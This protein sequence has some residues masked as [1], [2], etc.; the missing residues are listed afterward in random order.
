MMNKVDFKIAFYFSPHIRYTSVIFALFGFALLFEVPIAGVILCLLSLLF[1]TTHYRFAVDLDQKVYHDYLWIVG[2]KS[3]EK[4]KFSSIEYVF[5]KK[6]SVSQTMQLRVA[7]STIR[8]EV[9]DGYVKFS[10]DE[11]VH[12]LTLDSKEEVMARLKEISGQLSVKLVDYSAG[13]PRE[14]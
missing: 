7:S 2:F 8:K 13:T 14:I 10:P 4:K 3:G 11:K 5:I 12:L 6:S 9:F 1:I